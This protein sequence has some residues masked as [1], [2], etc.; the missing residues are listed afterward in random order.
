M[1]KLIELSVA[2]VHVAFDVESCRPKL[3]A[4][5]LNSFGNPI[6]SWGVKMAKEGF[7]SQHGLV[8][9]LTLQNCAELRGQTVDELKAEIEA[10]RFAYWEALGDENSTLRRTMFDSAKEFLTYDDLTAEP[11]DKGQLPKIK[12]DIGLFRDWYKDNILNAKILVSNTYVPFS[13]Q[14]RSFGF[15]PAAFLRQTYWPEMGELLYYGMTAEI[16][17]LEELFARQ[18]ADNDRTDQSNYTKVEQVL[19]G[20]RLF[21]EKGIN[22]SQIDMANALNLY[23]LNKK[24]G[25]KTLNVRDKQTIH[26]LARLCRYYRDH[27]SQDLPSRFQ[28]PRPGSKE[29]KYSPNGWVPI[30]RIKFEDLGYLL[31]T[32]KSDDFH[33]Q[34]E[35]VRGVFNWDKET[36]SHEYK[37]GTKSKP[38]I[39]TPEQLERYFAAICE[40][41]SATVNAKTR[42]DV[43]TYLQ[44]WG[45]TD[46]LV[47]AQTLVKMLYYPSGE[48]NP[49]SRQAMSTQFCEIG[50]TTTLNGKP[51][52]AKGWSSIEAD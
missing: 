1:S 27:Y 35:A 8:G 15:A 28:M 25:R 31:G 2:N 49:F 50:E 42:N 10:D 9:L 52:L 44:D 22:F 32:T 24:T 6:L 43:A 19:S 23:T 18:I 38:R 4:E 5:R 45:K 48:G 13:A 40:G 17:T 33:L 37:Q 16:P 51:L 36:E 39:V 30:D 12:L 7:N 47:S 21:D 3:N 34:S 26:G 41:A 20:I 29:A 11:D 46:W 14:R